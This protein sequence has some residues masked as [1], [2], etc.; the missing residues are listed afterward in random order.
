MRGANRVVGNAEIRAAGVGF[1][2]PGRGADGAGDEHVP[3]AEFAGA[4]RQGGG[5][6]G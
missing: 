2:G 3:P 6:P 1:D 4:A 5:A